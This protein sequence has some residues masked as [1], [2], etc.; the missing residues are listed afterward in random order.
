MLRQKTLG[1]GYGRERI[2]V[3]RD[4][5]GNALGIGGSK[6]AASRVGCGY[7]LGMGGSKF[8]ASRDGRGNG[9]GIG[10]SKFAAT[11]GVSE[12]GA[13]RS[14]ALADKLLTRAVARNA[15]SIPCFIDQLDC[16]RLESSTVR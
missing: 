14:P 16:F 2:Y 8:A 9:L 13:G 12:W 7:G 1:Q 15:A 10:G 6:F 11:L 3:K 5:C 4:G